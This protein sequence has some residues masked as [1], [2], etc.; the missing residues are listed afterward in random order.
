MQG[1]GGMGAFPD[2]VNLVVNTNHPLIANKLVSEKDADQQKDLAEY[3]YN[4]AR[5]N[6]NMLKGAELTR[7]I[8][9]SLEFLK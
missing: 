7:F 6:Q 2:S 3:L 4:L 8:N 1:M 9:K 5:L